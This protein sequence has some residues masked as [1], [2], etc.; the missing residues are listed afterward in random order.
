[1]I[2]TNL[3][4]EN[5]Y[6]LALQAESRTVCSLGYRSPACIVCSVDGSHPTKAQE[7]RKWTLVYPQPTGYSAF[8]C[9]T[10]H[11]SKITVIED[12]RGLI[13]TTQYL[14]ILLWWSITEPELFLNLSL[15]LWV[16]LKTFFAKRKADPVFKTLCD[17]SNSTRWHASIHF[18]LLFP[19]K[20][21]CAQALIYT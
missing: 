6:F 4:L 2:S 21:Y 9:S 8:Y 5:Y 16:K 7:F 11:M 20:V 18:H 10:T 3:L 13:R 19:K 17:T 12:Q 15:P 14:D 1:M